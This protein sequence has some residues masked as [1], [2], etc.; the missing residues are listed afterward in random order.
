L[1]PH[2][3]IQEVSDKLRPVFERYGIL[4]V[5][6]FCSIARGE[7][8]RRKSAF[9]RHVRPCTVR[10]SCCYMTSIRSG[11]PLDPSYGS[12]LDCNER[13]IP[14]VPIHRSIATISSPSSAKPAVKNTQFNKTLGY[15][16]LVT[17]MNGYG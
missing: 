13:P 16:N 10:T 2:D 17:F 9:L 11:P 14:F 12:D 1:K 6:V 8:C 7:P 4:M 5:I 3:L 15:P